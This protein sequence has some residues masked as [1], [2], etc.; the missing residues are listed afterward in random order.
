MKTLPTIAVAVFI[1]GICA[2]PLAMAQTLLLNYDFNGSNSSAESNAGSATGADLVYHNASKA[3]VNMY[4]A[5]GTGVSGAS[6]DTAM[7][8][9]S[10]GAMGTLGNNPAGASTTSKSA[11]I[12]TLGSFTIAGWFKADSTP[13]SNAKIFE[14]SGTETIGL[15]AEANQTGRLALTVNGSIVGNSTSQSGYASTGSWVFFAVTYDGTSTTNNLNFYLGTSNTSTAL[16]L[17]G[18]RSVSEGDIGIGTA[19]GVG[20]GNGYYSGGSANRP[21][22]GL[23]D[24]FSFYGAGAGS[25]AGVLSSTEINALRLQAIPEPSSLALLVGVVGLGFAGWRRVSRRE[26]SLLRV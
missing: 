19:A 2:A 22:D 9:T 15:I 7:D 10:A 24:D 26:G 12:G 8:N 21:F 4:S 16:S 14:L 20:I 3:V 25:S 18:T 13:G 6:G 23:I 1:Q 17:A 5:S 11:N